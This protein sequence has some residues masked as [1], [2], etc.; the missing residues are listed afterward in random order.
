MKNNYHVV[1]SPE[2][3]IVIPNELLQSMGVTPGEAFQIFRYENR[4]ELMPV[5]EI[6]EM[7]GAFKGVSTTVAREGDRV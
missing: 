6:T 5:K 7:R 2:N 4:I 3:G 1:V